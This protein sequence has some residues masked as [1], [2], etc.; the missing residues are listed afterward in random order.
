M[1]RSRHPLALRA[2]LAMFTACG[3]LVLVQGQTGF[4]QFS[5]TTQTMYTSSAAPEARELSGLVASPKYP[6]WYWSISDVWKPTDVDAACA[7]L[8]GNALSQCQQQERARTWAIRLDPVTHVV[9]E[10]RS[11]ALA[12]PAWALDPTIAQDNDWE[13]LALGP[14]RATADGGTTT[15]LVIAATGDSKNNRVFDAAGHD[16]TCDTRRLIEFTE[17]DLNDPSVTTWSPY[18]IFDLKNLVGTAAGTNACNVESVVAA[19]DATGVPQAY[20]VTRIGG[21]VLGRSLELSTG[22]D[23]ETPPAAVDSGLPYAPS[24]D[25]LGTVRLSQGAQFAAAATNGDDVALLSPATSKKPCQV[26]RWTLGGA[27]VASRLTSTDPAKPG[28]TVR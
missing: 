1:S 25:F 6:N 5:S 26:F 11:F 17:P 7:G 22:R 18:K 4:A 21:K 15:N 20:L 10:V 2:L 8:V 28:S 9:V 27:T 19:P 16:I 12:N 24:G 14:E 3:A 13:D 23:P